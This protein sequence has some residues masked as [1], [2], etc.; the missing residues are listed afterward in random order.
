MKQAVVRNVENSAG[1][2]LEVKQLSKPHFT[3][4]QLPNLKLITW[5]VDR[6]IEPIHVSP[7]QDEMKLLLY[8][9]RSGPIV[10]VKQEIGSISENSHLRLPVGTSVRRIS[11][12]F[13]GV[14]PRS[15][16]SKN[17][18]HILLRSSLR[19]FRNKLM[20]EEEWDG[21]IEGMVDELELLMHQSELPEIIHSRSSSCSSIQTISS[22]SADS[23]PMPSSSIL[24]FFKGRN[25]SDALAHLV[26]DHDCSALVHLSL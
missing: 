6:P 2:Q 26:P 4:S 13:T 20:C 5:P 3:T 19:T 7:T 18:R 24:E 12:R 25:P 23:S 14:G 21:V 22:G 9:A 17:V 11:S 8:F 10:D 1:V 15:K 16:T